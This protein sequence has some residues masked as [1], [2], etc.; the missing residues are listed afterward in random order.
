M[1]RF[2]QIGFW[3]LLAVG[4]ATGAGSAAWRWKIAPERRS[5]FDEGSRLAESLGCFGCHGPRGRGGVKNPGAIWGEVPSL[6]SGMVPM[7]TQGDEDIRE[8]IREGMSRRL[9][10]DKDYRARLRKQA[11]QMP[12]Y[13]DFLSPE[14]V[15]DLV[16]FLKAI[17]DAPAAEEERLRRA[18][19]LYKSAGCNG[20]HGQRGMGGV[21]NPGSLK[22]YIPGFLTD[23]FEELVKDRN[24]A[25]EWI[26]EGVV[27]R[28]AQNPLAQQFLDRQRGK[29]PAY[30]QHLS[31]EEV[32][33]LVDYVFWLRSAMP[34]L[35]AARSHDEVGANTGEE[36]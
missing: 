35:T 6:D 20:C 13:G 14:Q 4:A 5:A 21:P 22:G 1:Q 29:M 17:N 7:F 30:R 33:L 34:N 31:P 19:A 8:F 18:E 23:D 9:R 2:Y 24:E 11:I 27:Q 32:D 25:G 16:V 28:L 10:D 15:E 3:C 36:Q 26:R 12:A